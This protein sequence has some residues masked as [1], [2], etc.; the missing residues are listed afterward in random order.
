M[1]ALSVLSN[2]IAFIF[3][4]LTDLEILYISQIKKKPFYILYACRTTHNKIV[5]V[6]AGSWKNQ[7]S[8]LLINLDLFGRYFAGAMIFPSHHKY[9]MCKQIKYKYKSTNITAYLNKTPVC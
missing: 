2:A 6:H 8:G 7:G 4:A 3:I 5:P 9:V 1:F